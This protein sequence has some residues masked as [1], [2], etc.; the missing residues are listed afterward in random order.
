[1]TTPVTGPLQ[2]PQRNEIPTEQDPRW[3]AVVARDRAADGTFYYSVRTTGVYCRPSC[4]ARLANPKNVLF[5]RSCTEAERAGFRAC[6]R[7]KPGQPSLEEQHAATVARACR[8]IEEADEAPS[9]AGLAAAAGLSPFHFHR[10]FKAVAGVT[11]RDYAAARRAERVR[12]ELKARETVTE[13]IYGAGFNS[14]SRFYEDPVQSNRANPAVH[15]AR[16]VSRGQMLVLADP[17]REQVVAWLAI[18][19]R[20]P[21]QDRLAGLFGDLELHRAACHSLHNR[22]ARPHFSAQQDIVNP[23][24]HEIATPQLAVDGKV[25]HGEVAQAPLDLQ[26]DADGP[27]LPQF[28]RRL[29]ADELAQVPRLGRT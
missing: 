22:G 7:C 19:L 5:H 24:G 16:V 9:L 15:Q 4:A 28:E 23:Q 13:A 8:L 14:S 25:E 3:A 2:G 12:D 11:P 10:V 6:L 21:L 17:A 1:M 27:D 18:L 29:L 20:D 26:A